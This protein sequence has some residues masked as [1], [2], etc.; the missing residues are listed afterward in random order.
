MHVKGVHR[1]TAPPYALASLYTL[2][3]V[4]ALSLFTVLT[5]REIVHNLPTFDLCV[6]HVVPLMP[7][8]SV[9]I[10]YLIYRRRNRNLRAWQSSK[11]G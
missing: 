5:E 11:V 2:K 1:G 6:S 4:G 9:Y 7:L 10:I 8:S 3:V